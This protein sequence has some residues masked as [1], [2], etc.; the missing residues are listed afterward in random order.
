MTPKD[1]SHESPIPESLGGRVDFLLAQEVGL[2][3]EGSL[4][5]KRLK[6]I[7]SSLEII[8]TLKDLDG[9]IEPLLNV[10]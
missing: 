6:E 7:A 5:R 8:Q 9:K 2:L 1:T 10:K 3:E 4:C